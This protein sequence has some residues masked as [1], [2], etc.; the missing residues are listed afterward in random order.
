MKIFK[1]LDF[2]LF[3]KTINI[4]NKKYKMNNLLL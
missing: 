2:H 1:H 3:Y 4:Y